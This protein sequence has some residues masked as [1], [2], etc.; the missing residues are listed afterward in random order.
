MPGGIAFDAGRHSNVWLAMRNSTGLEK[1]LC[2]ISVQDY[3]RIPSSAK[4]RMK[5]MRKATE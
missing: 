1:L 3:T 2:P 5:M 4:S